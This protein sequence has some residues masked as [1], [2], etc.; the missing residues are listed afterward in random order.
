M[1]KEETPRRRGTA[2]A[3]ARPP[4]RTSVSLDVRTHAKLAA[5]AALRGVDRSTLAADFIRVGLKDVV[6]MDSRRKSDH[7]KGEDRQDLDF[8]VNPEDEETA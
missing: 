8:D 1:S 2:S 6:V 4:I 3:P 7:S 5:A